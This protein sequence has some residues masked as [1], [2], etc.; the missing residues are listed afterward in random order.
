M[1]IPQLLSQRFADAISQCPFADKIDDVQRFSGM[2]RIAGNPKFGDYQAN[3]AMPIS[4]LVGGLN[5]RD[6]AQQIVDLVKI[7]DLCDPPE[8]A[9]PG[10]INL[11]LRDD[12]IAAKMTSML[13]DPRCLVDSVEDPKKILIDY[14]SP[15]VAKPMH[16]GHIRT[17]VIGDCLAKTLSFIGH[18]VITDNHLGDWGTQFGMIIYGYKHFG[19]PDVVAADPVPELAKLY[20]LV[21][22]LMSYHKAVDS[23]P[24]LREQIDAF[25]Q[26]VDEAKSKAASAEGKEAKKLRKLAD[27]L[28]KKI[29]A[30]KESLTKAEATIQEIESDP[31]AKKR[32]DQHA[33]IATAVL[34]ETS[35]LHAGDEENKRLW[36]QFLP[37]C[38]DEINRVYKRL[39]VSFDHTL[40]ESFY[41]PMLRATVDDLQDRG[42]AKES[43]G[44]ICVFLD[45]FDAPMIIQKRDGAF[46]YATTDLATLKYREE[47]F[48]P[49]EILYVVDARQSEHFDKLFAVADLT[50]LTTAKLVHVSF[51]TVLGEDG[52][53]IKT[54]SGTL[55]GLESLLDD[56]VDAAHQVVCDPDRL[57]S[58]DPPMDDEE[59]RKVSETIGIGA[60]KYADLSHH[61]TSDYQFKLSKMVALSGN[62]ATYAQ[63]N[64]ARTPSILQRNGV[65]EQDVHQRVAKSGLQLTHPA[66]RD[67]AL[68]LLRFEESLRS[69]YEDYA[70]N[71]LVDYVYG[72][73]ETFA[74]FNVQCH[75]LRAESEEIQ[76]TRLALVLLTGRVLQ[77]GLGLLGIDVVERM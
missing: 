75:V 15:N 53:P 23:L 32:A 43:D 50:K 63:Y 14:S 35:K 3:F 48:S 41:H 21:H 24:R 11:K 59:K 77:T 69:V 42:L 5:P 61:R 17:T 65:T 20:R 49:D 45:Q 7:D 54:R 55:I 6:V 30:C 9:G 38:K 72:L 10:F 66:E 57:V 19:D 58:L 36:E 12:Y 34:E 47:E 28:G 52:K 31:D 46:L 2:I 27:S 16:V 40:G 8:V 64:Y 60:I 70:P 71:H 67:L 73:A 1:H 33:Q 51:G 56:A 25:G 44:A 29:S 18:E 39:N 62:T 13:D 26:Q 68:M 22:Q 37:Y 4:K 74:K 76:T